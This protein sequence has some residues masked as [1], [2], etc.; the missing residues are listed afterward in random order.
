MKDAEPF[1][2]GGAS[3]K[4]AVNWIFWWE[5]ALAVYSII[6][7]YYVLPS[8]LQPFLDGKSWD[9]AICGR[10][11]ALDAPSSG[12]WAFIFAVS[13]GGRKWMGERPWIVLIVAVDGSFG[14]RHAAACLGCSWRHQGRHAFALI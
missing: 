9:Q 8:A 7:A 2:L 12:Y 3:T 11:D 6:G 10:G 5:T 14:G 1:D 4:S 13:S